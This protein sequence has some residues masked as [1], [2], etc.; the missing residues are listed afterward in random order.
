MLTSR[1]ER[2]AGVAFWGE[3]VLCLCLPSAC[4]VCGAESKALTGPAPWR[5]ASLYDDH[6]R[7][8]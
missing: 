3:H 1:L 7:T 5:L 8:F 4:L 2:L 6:G